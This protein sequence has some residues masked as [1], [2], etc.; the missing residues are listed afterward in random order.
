MHIVIATMQFGEGYHQGTE[1]YIQNLTKLL[2]HNKV[3]VTILAGDPDNLFPDIPYNFNI[4]K[5]KYSII[6]MRTDNWYTVKGA[7]SN[8]YKSL[9]Q[10]LAPDI[11]HLVNPAHIGLNIIAAAKHLKIKTVLTITD[12]WWLCPKSTLITQH[13]NLCKGNKDS[14]ECIKC[15]A[16]TSDSYQHIKKIPLG[17]TALNIG[18]R[19]LLNL[20]NIKMDWHNRKN[21]IQ[22]TFS[23]IDHVIFLSQTAKNSLLAEYKIAN[24][25]IIPAGLK[26]YWFENIPKNINH[27]P[28]SIGFAG[29]I[30]PHKG[31]HILFLALKEI[32]QP[33]TIKIAGT[34][35]N[36][37]YLQYLNQINIPH[38][39]IWLGQLSENDMI[40]FIDSVDLIVVPSLSPENQPQVILEAHARNKTVICSDVPGAAELVEHSLTYP[41]LNYK[42]LKDRLTFQLENP[43]EN[44]NIFP[45]LSIID[46]TRKTLNIYNN[47]K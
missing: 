40:K 8:T 38:K 32:T 19:T 21:I 12:F 5:S 42:D 13:G 26:N 29:A 36:N 9:L 33:L 4:K 39:V 45:P 6:K 24:F 30:S 27:K 43:Y 1:K 14:N 7:A 41:A 16:A 46:M 25:S 22:Q 20:K 15:I 3:K 18:L 17:K 44:V 35:A 31:L 47:I 11:I 37:S 34:C 23:N 28:K 10:S 2:E